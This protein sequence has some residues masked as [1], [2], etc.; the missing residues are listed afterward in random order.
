[1]KK[2]VSAVSTVQLGM[3][4]G[5]GVTGGTGGNGG[6]DGGSMYHSSNGII[7]AGGGDKVGLG[8][9]ATTARE[10][11]RYTS[12]RSC[13]VSTSALPLAMVRRALCAREN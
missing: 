11:F 2:A 10:T 6:I 5:G 1:M 3:G 4:D 9:G 8:G 7:G 12:P 13:A